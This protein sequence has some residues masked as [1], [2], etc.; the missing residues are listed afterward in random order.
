MQSH[1]G[2]F[3]NEQKRLT[4]PKCSGHTAFVLPDLMQQENTAG[5]KKDSHSTTQNS[6]SDPRS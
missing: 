5:P 6:E 4:E 2:E 1:G 3:C